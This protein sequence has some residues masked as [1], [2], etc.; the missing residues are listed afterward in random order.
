MHCQYSCGFGSSAVRCSLPLGR[1]V[2]GSREEKDQTS[3]D[4]DSSLLQ[5]RMMLL[6][7]LGISATL[8][9][10]AGEYDKEVS[11]LSNENAELRVQLATLRS[12]L[13]E[14]RDLLSAAKG[15]LLQQ[16]RPHFSA[17]L[18]R[19]DE[20]IQ[21]KK[22][23]SFDPAVGMELI[24]PP[25]LDASF[26]SKIDHSF[27]VSFL[28]VGA[29]GTGTGYELATDGVD[30][31]FRRALPQIAT[32][33]SRRSISAPCPSQSPGWA[34]LSPLRE[35]TNR[36]ESYVGKAPSLL[37]ESFGVPGSMSPTSSGGSR[38]GDGTSPGGSTGGSGVSVQHSAESPSSL[39]PEMRALSDAPAVVG[40]TTCRS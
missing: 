11:A 8:R 27:E 19:I 3:Q 5:P 40:V 29:E 23:A 31:A 24:D 18:P 26:I 13:G 22:K 7:E 28:D 21:Q 32:S 6:D 36:F 1:S 10:L 37:E 30:G 25:S 39:L 38:L 16:A 15:L 9:H 35:V 2:D 4:G 17:L 33:N 12:A 14:Q 34:E 20:N